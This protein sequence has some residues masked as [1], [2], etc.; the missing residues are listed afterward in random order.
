MSDSND[1]QLIRSLPDLIPRLRR[2][3]SFAAVVH[4]LERGDSGTIDGA[5]GSSSALATAA[6]DGVLRE[7]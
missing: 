1:S 3:E 2:V 6:L 4:A 7:Q 5:W